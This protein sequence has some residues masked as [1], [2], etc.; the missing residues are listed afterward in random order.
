[1][2]EYVHIFVLF[3]CEY[4]LG[5]GYS[6]TP[7][8]FFFFVSGLTMDD[9]LDDFMPLTM[10]GIPSKSRYN[11]VSLSQTSISRL[12]RSYAKTKKKSVPACQSTSVDNQCANSARGSIVPAVGKNQHKDSH[13]TSVNGLQF[14]PVCQAPFDILTDPHMHVNKCTMP[15]SELKGKYI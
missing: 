8:P 12:S 7:P 15:C 10:T 4:V 5:L 11:D 1:M 2:R 9:E 3:I 13:H 6:C 14:C